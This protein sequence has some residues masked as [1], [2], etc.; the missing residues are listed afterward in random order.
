MLKNFISGGI[1]LTLISLLLISCNQE[2]STIPSNIKN[3]EK[4][5]MEIKSLNSSP[6]S[7]L[8]N[9]DIIPGEYIVKYKNTSNLSFNTLSTSNFK[10]VKNLGGANSQFKLVK[11]D[12]TKI[13]ASSLDS[14]ANIEYIEPNRVITLPNEISNSGIKTFSVTPTYP[15]DP[16]LSKQWHHDKIKTINGWQATKKKETVIAIIDSGID[17]THPDLQ[18]SLL[19]GYDTFGNNEE[20]FDKVGHGTHCAGIA[21][22]QVNNGIGGDGI[23]NDTKLVSVKVLDDTGSGSYESVVDGIIWA[24][25]NPSVDILSMSL[26]GASSS[27]ALIDAVN[28]AKRNGKIIVAAMGNNGTNQA[29]YPASIKGVI[30]V[31]ATDLNDA[32]ADFSQWGQNITISAPGVDI[33][34]TLPTYANGMSNINYGILSGTSMACPVVAGTLALIKSINPSLTTDELTTIIKNS[35][36][37]IGTIGFDTKFGY[38]RIN[39]AKAVEMLKQYVIN[40]STIS[41][42]ANTTTQS[43][44][45]ITGTKFTSNMTAFING[46][47][48]SLITVTNS[49]KATITFNRPEVNASDLTGNLSIT[50]NGDTAQGSTVTVPKQIPIIPTITYISSPTNTTTQSKFTVTGTNYTSNMTASINGIQ[51]STITVTSST[52]ASII[53]NR[54]EAIASDLIGNLSITLNGQTGQSSIVTVPKQILIIPTITYISSPANTTTQSKFTVNGTNFTSNMNAYINGIQAST[55]T[56][57]SSTK[58]SIIFNRPQASSSDLTGNLSITLNGQTGQGSIVT[59]LKQILIIPTITYI[60]KP[61]NTTTQSK[62]TITGT[63]FTSNMTASINGIQASIITVTSSTKATIIFNRPQASASSLTGNLS[64]ILNGQ[65]G[66]GSSVT[67]PKI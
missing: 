65:T 10:K 47:Q 9:G 17:N 64:I 3:T 5:T 22:A 53:F 35:A 4:N 52:K 36:D 20:Y 13:T 25:N 34:S 57:T 27:Q 19:A 30:A 16:D 33:Y 62:F 40:I 8:K 45:T 66:Q 1:V 7:N 49:T 11:I 6:T 28:L 61:V 14:D 67:V 21:A 42:P 2:V 39:V 60:S 32:K 50:L 29:S 44:F 55:I 12:T 26:G 54:P 38:G 43:K 37:D 18:N 56:V 48:A 58:A 46:V 31:G 24:A 63:N 51:A 15:N 59:V 23:A 41:S